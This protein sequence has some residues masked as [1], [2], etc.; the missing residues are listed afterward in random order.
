M[1]SRWSRN[2]SRLK[3]P[4]RRLRGVALLLRSLQRP[5]EERRFIEKFRSAARKERIERSLEE[6][7]PRKRSSLPQR[8]WESSAEPR[9][10]RSSLPVLPPH[11]ALLGQDLKPFQ[12]RSIILRLK[13]HR[14]LLPSPQRLPPLTSQLEPLPHSSLR[15]VLPKQPT[16]TRKSRAF[17]SCRAEADTLS[18]WEVDDQI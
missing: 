6:F 8:S 4:K 15:S 5:E 3:Q 17:R 10:L 12:P 9:N 18:G 13:R 2:V 14:S 16:H 11:G 1:L 7:L